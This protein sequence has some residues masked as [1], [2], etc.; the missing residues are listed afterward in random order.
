RKRLYEEIEKTFMLYSQEVLVEEF[1]EGRELTVGILGNENPTVLPILE[2]DFTNCRESGEFFYSWRMKEYQGDESLHLVP[3]FFC[4]ARLEEDTTK[5]VKEIALKAYRAL[6]CFDLSRVDIR[7]GYDNIPYVLEINPLP[8]L[9]PDESNLTFMTNAA[10]IPY[11]D[12][13]N[14]ILRNAQERL[15]LKGQ[16][17]QKGES[18]I[19]TG[20]F[21][22][23]RAL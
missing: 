19:V 20:E 6:G 12:L 9:D 14:G 3:E 15:K 7:L 16:L 22:A 21:P 10:N 8:G 18:K 1:I 4:P 11:R 17:S 5:V 23:Y 2:V 13:I